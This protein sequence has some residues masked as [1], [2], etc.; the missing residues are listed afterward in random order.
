MTN[1]QTLPPNDEVPV[2][3]KL[4]EQTKVVKD[5]VSEL[6]RL[7]RDASREKLDQAREAAG[8]Y[9]KK[10]RLKAEVVEDKV[11]HYVREKPVKSVLMAVGAGALLGF[12]LR[13]R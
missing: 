12:L 2:T 3:Q 9:L 4:R 7:T 10:G 13:R 8:D 11:V 6:G 1:T 5:D